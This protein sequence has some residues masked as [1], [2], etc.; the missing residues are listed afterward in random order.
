[1][2]LRQR[3]KQDSLNLRYFD[4]DINACLLALSEENFYKTKTYRDNY[5]REKPCDSYLITHIRPS[6]DADDLYVK[7]AFNGWIVVHSFH[8]QH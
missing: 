1:M 7:F 3:A 2:V 4:D 8:L 6:G 5:A